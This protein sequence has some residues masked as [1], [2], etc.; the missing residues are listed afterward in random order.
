MAI[1]QV[2]ALWEYAFS[3]KGS[4]ILHA[5]AIK[6]VTAL[7]EYDRI[8]HTLAIKQVTAFNITDVGVIGSCSKLCSLV[9]QKTGSQI[10]GVVCDL[11]CD[12][13]GIDEFIKLIQKWVQFDVGTTT[14]MMMMRRI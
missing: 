1:K 2:T 10:I 14:V 13:L 3:C 8:A 4:F 7:W 9:E 6:R 11:G 12:I 5:M